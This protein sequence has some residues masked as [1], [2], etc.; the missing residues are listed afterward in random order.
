MAL[1]RRAAVP[2]AAASAM[3][4]RLAEVGRALAQGAKVDVVSAYAAIGDE[5]DTRPLLLALATSGFRVALP[6][7]GKRGTPLVFRQWTPT[8]PMVT[9]RMD[10]PEPPKDAPHLVPD[11]LF[12]PLAAFD[13]RGHR[14]GYGAGFYDRSLSALRAR[15]TIL[16]VGVAYAVQEIPAVPHDAYDQ[17][18]DMIVTERDV[19]HV[20]G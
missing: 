18:L 14:I 10:I 15:K 1:E 13:R 5:I 4:R 16:A 17:A 7:T 20:G 2:L 19:I 12:V 6:I 11:M 9:G 8:T 3:A